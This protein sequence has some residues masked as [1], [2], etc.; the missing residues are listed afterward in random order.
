MVPKQE[1]KGI[2]LAIFEK[3]F[4]NKFVSDLFIYLFEQVL[5]KTWSFL[6]SKIC[7]TSYYKKEDASEEEIILQNC[8][9][10]FQTTMSRAILRFYLKAINFLWKMSLLEV[11]DRNFRKIMSFLV[12]FLPFYGDFDDRIDWYV[13]PFRLRYSCT[14]SLVIQYTRER[15]VEIFCEFLQWVLFSVQGFSNTIH[16]KGIE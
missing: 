8:Q 14:K 10:Y 7:T 1:T 5:S 16:F 15:T 4:I 12:S 3:H 13:H 11:M 9:K 2:H 6:Y